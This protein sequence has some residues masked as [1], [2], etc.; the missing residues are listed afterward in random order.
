MIATSTAIMPI[1]TRSSTSV[2]PRRPVMCRLP[3][4]VV[5]VATCA[6]AGG[7]I[8]PPVHSLTLVGGHYCLPLGRAHDV[9][10]PV[11]G[12]CVPAPVAVGADERHAAVRHGEDGRGAAAVARIPEA[13]RRAAV[14]A[15]Q[16][17]PVGGR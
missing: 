8:L 13:D 10:D 11:F 6:H 15:R 16:Q 5:P 14:Q 1:T 2:K 7:I 4:V 17:S 12:L 9:D 3:G